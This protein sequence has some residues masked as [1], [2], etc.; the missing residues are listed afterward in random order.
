MSAVEKHNLHSTK[1][2]TEAGIELA[3]KLKTAL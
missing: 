3:E 2:G 1:A